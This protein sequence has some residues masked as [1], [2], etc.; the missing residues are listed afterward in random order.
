MPMGAM[1]LFV[2]ELEVGLITDCN[3][4][5]V[6]KHMSSSDRK[7][8]QRSK[9]VKCVRRFCLAVHQPLRH[10]HNMKML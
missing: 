2:L 8:K 7:L 6:S 4:T 1:K 9:R 10:C 5:S 3:N